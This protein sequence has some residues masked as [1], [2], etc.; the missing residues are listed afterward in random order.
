MVHSLLGGINMKRI[1][2]L[3]Q[4]KHQN[5]GVEINPPAKLSDI[6]NFEKKIGFALPTDFSCSVI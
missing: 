5:N 1:I 6:H 2:E 4:K 3:V